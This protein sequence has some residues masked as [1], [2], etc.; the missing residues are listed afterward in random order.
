MADITVGFFDPFL[1]FAEL[2]DLKLIDIREGMIVSLRFDR[3]RKCA[4][5]VILPVTV[6][7]NQCLVL[8]YITCF[9]II[10]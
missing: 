8:Y 7:I 9:E 1:S 4:C 3:A 10:G 5:Y 2:V 6:L